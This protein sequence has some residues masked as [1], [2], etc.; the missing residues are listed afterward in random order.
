MPMPAKGEKLRL[1]EISQVTEDAQLQKALKRLA[2]DKA[3]QTVAQLVMWKVAADR[4]WKQIEEMSRPWANPYE[5]TLAHTFVDRLATLTSEEAGV[6]QFEIKSQGA[7]GDAIALAP[8]CAPGEDGAGLEGTGRRSRETQGT[9]RSPARS[10]SRAT[11]A[12]VQVATSDGPARAWSAAAA[13]RSPW[14]RPRR[15][16]RMQRP[17]RTAWPRAS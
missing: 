7:S 16:N 14:P 10:R 9:S 3:P 11:K 15:R 17:R 12:K 6:L 4:D 1:G 13:S 8:D 2:E 5:L